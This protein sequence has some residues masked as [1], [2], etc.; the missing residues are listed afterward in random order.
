MKHWIKYIIVVWYP[1]IDNC[2]AAAAAAE[3]VYFFSAAAASA[4]CPRALAAADGETPRLF[5][6]G[7][8]EQKPDINIAMQFPPLPPYL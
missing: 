8:G 5:P 2:A 6:V 7:G 4:R 1:E 3:T